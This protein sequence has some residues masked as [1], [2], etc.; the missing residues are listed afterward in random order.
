[1]LAEDLL[2]AIRE[3]VAWFPLSGRTAIEV[4]GRDRATFLH[5]FC[6]NDIKKLQPGQGC[7]AFFCN[8]KGR[9][10]GHGNIVATEDALWIDSVPS[11][12]AKLMA[13]LDRY[14][15]RE[16][17]TLHDRTT[18]VASTY[19]SGPRAL[20]P[21]FALI[22]PLGIQ[23]KSAVCLRQQAE[24]L[25]INHQFRLLTEFSDPEELPVFYLRSVDWLGEQ[26]YILTSPQSDPVEELHGL[27]GEMI[28]LQNIQTGTADDFEALRI[29]A[30]WPLFGIDMT[31]DNLPQ[32]VARTAQAISFTKGCYLGQE[33]IARLDALGHTNRELR[34]LAIDT[35]T[36]PQAGTE[37]L[38]QTT[39]DIVGQITS[40][41]PAPF[42]PGVVALGYL[43]TK[44]TKPGTIVKLGTLPGQTAT[45]QPL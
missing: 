10:I 15:I 45:V 39:D 6:T 5:N 11:Q 32:E 27:G 9:V 3:S 28:E 42:G 40:A 37:L 16:D 4:T 19:L 44:W 35:E 36:R 13:H 8:A 1:M 20:E 25:P 31:E 26:G 21:L 14:I 30:G 41:A 7:E 2:R 12:S 18:E 43:K 17:V 29:A 23:E 33:P 38:D 34:R 24:L 22:S